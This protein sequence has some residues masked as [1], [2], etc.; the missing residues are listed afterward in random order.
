ML[1]VNKIISSSL[2][3]NIQI[4]T[5]TKL[6]KIYEQNSQIIYDVKLGELKQCV[7]ESLSQHT[8]NTEKFK[9][10]IEQVLNLCVEH[11]ELGIC[12]S[13]KKV[14]E[15][16]N[17]SF[18]QAK[19]KNIKNE[20]EWNECVE[21]VLQSCQKYYSVGTGLAFN[22]FRDCIDIA[23]KFALAI[24]D[25]KEL[26]LS[27]SSLDNVIFDQASISKIETV[28]LCSFALASSLPVLPVYA[29]NP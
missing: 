15:F 18:K 25:M 11:Y 21:Q 2:G 20:K 26:E 16:I 22:K 1:G 9:Q 24:K 12:S 5:N 19:V 17:E 29:Q 6:Y 27:F 10:G 13:F 7:N 23:F 28:I 8:K 4:E 14:Q 3:Q